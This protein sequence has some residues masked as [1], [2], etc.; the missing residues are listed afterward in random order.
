MGITRIISYSDEPFFDRREAGQLLADELRHLS[1]KETVVL[2]IPRGGIV[3][4]AELAEALHADLDIVLSRKLGAP[5][6]PELAIGAVSENGKFL[7]NEEWAFQVG[8]NKAYIEEE[9][10]RQWKEITRRREWYR[11]V[12]PKIDLKG[13]VVIV[14][15]DG[16]ATGATMEAALWVA[17]QEGPKSLIG[18]VPVGAEDSLEK[19][20]RYADELL[21]MRLPEFFAA[22]GQF[23]LN[24]PQVTDEEV[25]EILKKNYRGDSKA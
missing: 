8:A 3:V 9:K 21:C 18:A 13:K 11:D 10:A 5:G 22:V 23:Y 24:F 6:N 12:R 20:T 17:R 4:A 7:I 16:I 25:L 1:D 15:D 2:G 14:T 19:L